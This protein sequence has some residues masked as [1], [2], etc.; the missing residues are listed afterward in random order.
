MGNSNSQSTNVLADE[1]FH[2]YKHVFVYTVL[3]FIFAH[4]SHTSSLSDFLDPRFGS[5]SPMAISCTTSNEVACY[6]CAVLTTINYIVPSS[7]FSAALENPIPCN[8]VI[9]A[10]AIAR[11]FPFYTAKDEEVL[12]LHEY[13]VLEAMRRE[14]RRLCVFQYGG[15][16]MTKSLGVKKD[17]GCFEKYSKCSKPAYTM[18][19]GDEK[20]RL[21]DRGLELMHKLVEIADEPRNSGQD[22]DVLARRLIQLSPGSSEDMFRKVT[23]VPY[24]EIFALEKARLLAIKT[25]RLSLNR[26]CRYVWPRWGNPRDRPKTPEDT[27]MEYPTRHPEPTRYTCRSILRDSPEQGQLLPRTKSKA[28]KRRL[29]LRTTRRL[30]SC[31]EE[32]STITLR[33]QNGPYPDDQHFPRALCRSEEDEAGLRAFSQ[34]EASFVRQSLE[35][36]PSSQ[37]GNPFAR[38]RQVMKGREQALQA[39]GFK[40]ETEPVDSFVD[41]GSLLS[42]VEAYHK[43]GW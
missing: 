43:R 10:Q 12:S 8:K 21:L 25:A 28:S 17:R 19:N 14:S 39:V 35:L 42:R 16:T 15:K 11:S 6:L 3:E 1:D 26:Q 37:I 18:A 7:E 27:E 38:H 20:L 34:L 22:S 23:L 24:R 32:C 33:I 41:G 31:T 5:T 4:S 29:P 40:A 30:K 13:G 9:E 2:T 36:L